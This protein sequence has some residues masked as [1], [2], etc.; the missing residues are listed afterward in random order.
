MVIKDKIF[1][2]D[3]VLLKFNF[4]P[5]YFFT[6]VRTPNLEFQDEFKEKEEIIE[7]FYDPTNTFKSYNYMLSKLDEVDKVLYTFSIQDSFNNNA[8]DFCKRLA[9]TPE[10]EWLSINDNDSEN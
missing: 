6:I 2:Y 3:N 8:Y 9:E 4:N 7:V 1:R 10:S 5:L